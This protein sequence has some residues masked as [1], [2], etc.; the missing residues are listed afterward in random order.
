MLGK[1]E[2]FLAKNNIAPSDIMYIT[3]E[4]RQSVFALSCGK[5]EVSYIPIKYIYELLPSGS[6]LNI[7][8]GVVINRRHISEIDGGMYIMSDGTRFRGRVRTPGAHS[9]N[10]RMHSAGIT[11]GVFYDLNFG[12]L[13]NCPIPF[14]AVE[15]VHDSTG[16]LIDY[17]FRY[18]NLAFADFERKSVDQLT[19]SAFYS[20]FSDRDS[21]WIDY[22]ERREEKDGYF[23][24]ADKDEEGNEILR[25]MNY[26]IRPGLVGCAVINYK[27]K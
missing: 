14:C 12:V 16:R 27:K 19:G 5:R 4:N 17:I 13:D 2:R 21:R 25:T 22:E 9:H 6:F 18:V 23:E 3:R 10:R 24:V 15:L 8:K 11:E 20:V 7:T 26:H 1:A